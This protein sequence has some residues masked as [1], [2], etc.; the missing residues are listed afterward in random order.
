MGKARTVTLDWD[1]VLAGD[2]ADFPPCSRGEPVEPEFVLPP[3][4]HITDLG[5]GL[6]FLGTD[7]ALAIAKAT[8][9]T[10]GPDDADH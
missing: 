4:E 1:T 5:G 3:D 6:W 10:K 2:V 7:R 8:W 9:A